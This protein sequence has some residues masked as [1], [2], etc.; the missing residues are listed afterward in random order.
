MRFG[1]AASVSAGVVPLVLLGVPSIAAWGQTDDEPSPPT[2]RSCWHCPERR[3]PGWALLEISTINLTAMMYHRVV[4]HQPTRYGVFLQVWG[5]TKGPGW[6][7]SE[8]YMNQFGHPYTG[9]LYFT[10]TR[11]HGFD[12]WAAIPFTLFGSA[13]AEFLMTSFLASTNDL[14]TTTVGG[15]AL[16]E[17]TLRLSNALQLSRAARGNLLRDIAAFVLNPPSLLHGA[18]VRG[19]YARAF[20]NHDR[21]FDT[22]LNLGLRV[23]TDSVPGQA[24]RL[25]FV[26]FR[27]DYGDPFDR[28][29]R[30][31]FDHFEFRGRLDFT[32]R[33]L[34]RFRIRGSLASTPLGTDAEPS[35]AIGVFQHF[36]Y[37]ERMHHELG[38]QSVSFGWHSR[39]PVGAVELKS[40]VDAVAHMLGAVGSVRTV[41][42]D[43]RRYDYVSGL[44]LKVMGRLDHDD[45]VLASLEYGGSWY[46]VWNGTM[47]SHIDHVLE[48][49]VL[50]P[51]HGSLTLGTDVEYF[52]RNS[53]YREVPGARLR[54]L[55]VRLYLGLSLAQ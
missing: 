16:A 9:K 47:G 32:G 52:F 34:S 55:D 26:E 19:S 48:A 10:T 31:P 41:I 51:V 11:A 7:K 29:N 40:R 4:R 18:S 39:A 25:G 53:N 13:Q 54:A 37:D 3:A 44:G 33:V 42:G 2:D 28:A 23:P 14:F 46:H 5:D 17:A 6:D 45:R 15:S 36:E 20:E 24:D 50:V 8:M 22:Q 43:D 49:R 12:Y 38:M 21:P 27:F 30:E 1:T 35:H